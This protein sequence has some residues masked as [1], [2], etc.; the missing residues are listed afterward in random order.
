M[1]DTGRA[2]V[3]A[4]GRAAAEAVAQ[5]DAVRR[6]RIGVVVPVLNEAARI[7]AAIARACAMS[8]RVV[9]VDG[10][11]D[12]GSLGRA[13]AWPSTPAA[14]VSAMTAQRG[15]A[16]QMNA[17]AQCCDREILVFL[18]ADVTPPSDAGSA[19]V[20]AIDAG[21]HWGRFDVRLEPSSMLLRIVA[22]MMNLRS[23]VTGI[24]TG[25]QVLFVTRAAFEAAGG[26]P[27]LEL[28]EDIELS[29]RLKRVAGRPACL[30]GPVTVDA[31]RWHRNGVL[32]TIVQMWWLRFLFWRGADP[33][34]LRARYQGD[35]A[36]RGDPR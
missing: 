26:F 33:R 8:D 12:D 4:G 11:S 22:A 27:A 6:S 17:G 7:D 25:D 2:V 15:R 23:R 20:A 34:D 14:R 21:A 24:A 30:D 18:H 3:G 9:V 31:R 29:S 35:G 1:V 28:M 16:S 10:G 32:R 36:L 13:I 5:H 19:I